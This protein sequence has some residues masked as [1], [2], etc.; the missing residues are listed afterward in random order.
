MTNI[1][2]FFVGITF[3]FQNSCFISL[4]QYVVAYA[5]LFLLHPSK[6]VCWL[7]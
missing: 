2:L 5:V 3:V 7:I 4:I 1:S 6:S